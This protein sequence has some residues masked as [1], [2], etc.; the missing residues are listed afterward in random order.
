MAH[1]SS[2]LLTEAITA[3]EK[4]KVDF[5]D[6]AWIGNVSEDVRVC[7]VRSALGVRTWPELMARDAGHLRRDR[8]RAM[9]ATSTPR[10][11]A[12]CSA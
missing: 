1:F 6:F 3:P 11:C 10:C 5:R 4:V 9:P 8:R 7:Y 2:G 12:I